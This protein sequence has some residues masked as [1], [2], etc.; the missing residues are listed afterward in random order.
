MTSSGYWFPEKNESLTFWLSS[1]S[2]KLLDAGKQSPHRCVIS[3]IGGV[4]ITGGKDIKLGDGARWECECGKIWELQVT[5]GWG[6]EQR[7]WKKV[8]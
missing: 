2:G 5:S 8:P 3:E 4:Y 6:R 7:D 1:M